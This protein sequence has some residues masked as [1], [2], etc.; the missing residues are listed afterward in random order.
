MR[1]QFKFASNSSPTLKSN[2]HLNMVDLWSKCLNLSP[3]KISYFL[4]YP[5]ISPI[6]ILS[7]PFIQ[8][9]KEFKMRKIIVGRFLR[10][11]PSSASTPDPLPHVKSAC[12]RARALVI[13][14]QD[15]PVNF[16]FPQFPSSTRPCGNVGRIAIEELTT[17]HHPA[18]QG[19]P[20]VHLPP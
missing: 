1:I 14:G 20:L 19:W 2:F 6:F 16:L 17:R 18:S 7:C 12:Y 9:E 8:L 5:S 3:C 15:P 13:D 10:G 11:R 4:R